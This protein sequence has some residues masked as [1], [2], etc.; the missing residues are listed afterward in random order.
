MKDKQLKL[1]NFDFTVITLGSLISLAG[2]AVAGI[3]LGFIAIQKT[4]ANIALYALLQV[5]FALPAALAPMLAGPI[6]DRIPR[7]HIIYT[8][9]FFSAALYVALFFL[10][11]NDF[12]PYGLQ[13]CFTITFGCIQGVYTVAYD[14]LYP[15]LVSPRNM[16]RAYA[17]G[18]MMWPLAAGVTYL[19]SAAALESFGVEK[20]FLIVAAAFL[21]AALF[22]TLV[23]KKETHLI[24]EKKENSKARFQFFRDLREG[25]AYLKSEK[26]LSGIV[27]Y[28]FCNAIVWGAMSAMLY[29]YFMASYGESQGLRIYTMLMTASTLGRLL[30]GGVQFFVKYPTQKKFAIALFVYTILCFIE[31]GYL[32]I[33]WLG[34]M[35][36]VHALSGLLAVTSYNIRTSSTQQYVPDAI[37][38]RFN[39]VFVVL[40]TLGNALGALTAALLG[41]A[42]QVPLA[43][44]VLNVINLLVIFF[45]L[46]PRRKDVALIYNV[47]L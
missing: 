41:S 19:F 27:W 8:L 42:M 20:L 17:I 26:G 12:L 29:P 35:L 24:Q 7:K 31:G 38:A 22:E 23:R 16:R 18:S 43:I 40:N 45:V 4:N 25:F 11:K 47:D 6:L 30:G 13:L 46:L 2:N 1:W 15:N 44:A 37:R 33:P 14:S 36:G 28:F 3:A 21:V 32:Y 5:C 34:V 9:D 10:V 39:S